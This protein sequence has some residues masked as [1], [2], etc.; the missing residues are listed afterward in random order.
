MVALPVS[1]ITGL[2][3]SDGL[4]ATNFCS[5]GVEFVVGGRGRGRGQQR[6]W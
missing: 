5:A 3:S 1:A 2:L 4:W 6:L